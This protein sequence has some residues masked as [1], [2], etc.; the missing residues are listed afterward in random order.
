MYGEWSGF[1]RIHR[2][3]TEALKELSIY[4]FTDLLVEY[5]QYLHM[6]TRPHR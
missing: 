3:K 2:K 5:I 6:V 1:D 4:I